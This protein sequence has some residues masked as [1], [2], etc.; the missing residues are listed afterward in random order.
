MIVPTR[1]A[2]DWVVSCLEAVRAADPGEVILVDGRSDDGT[3]MLAENLADQIIRD[4]G[5]GPGAAR[6]RG[7]EAASHPWVLFVDVDVLLPAGAVKTLLDEATARGL[8]G[9][10]ASLR[11]I[12]TDY[13]SEQLAWHHNHGRSRSWFGVSAT[14]L[15]TE[16]ARSHPFDPALRSGEDA[17]LRIRLAQDGVAV[18]VSEQVQVVHRFAPGLAS[19]R[20]QWADDGAG[21]GRLVRKHG[22]PAL[23]LLAVPFGAAAYWIARTFRAPRRIPYFVGFLAGN[24]RSA[25]S[26]LLDSRVPLSVADGRSAVAVGVV[27]LLTGAAGL[28]LIAFALIVVLANLIPGVPELLLGAA[29]LPVLAGLAVLGLVGLELIATLPEGHRL[30]LRARRYRSRILAFVLVMV[31]LTALRLL[32][33]LRLLN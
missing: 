3:V 32:A 19:A 17:D 26:G 16:V 4:D 14:L 25:L 7:V 28:G 31:I 23:R 21:L 13:W 8:D 1:N 9:L 6:N 2:A 30:A 29:V 33:N 12:G 10:Q 24:W 15:R 22:R 5:Q 18:G 20:T 11:S 27:A